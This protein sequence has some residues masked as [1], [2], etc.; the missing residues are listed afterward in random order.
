MGGQTSKE[1]DVYSY[2]ILVLEMLAGRR[3]TDEIFENGLNLHSFVENA[4]P[5]K[6]LQIVDPTVV[7]REVTQIDVA[8]GEDRYSDED[9]NDQIEAEEEG[10]A[11]YKPEKARKMDGNMQSCLQSVLN[12]ALACSM[13]S[14][15]H[16]MSMADVTRELHLIKNAFLNS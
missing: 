6:L 5:E 14:P 12:I 2:G 4:L 7:P 15:L 13:E 11:S 1:G 16:R 10:V 8:A 3:P 9:E